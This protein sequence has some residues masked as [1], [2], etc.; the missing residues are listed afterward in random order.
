[1]NCIHLASFNGN[2]GDLLSHQGTYVM[3]QNYVKKKIKFTEFEIRDIYNKK[4]K[5]DQDFVNYVNTFDFLMI[6]GGNY[7]ELWVK[8]SPTGT[9][10]SIELSLL[11]KIKIPIL[12]NSMGVDIS[13]GA[14]KQNIKKFKRFI[15][16]LIKKNA[17][18]SF[19]NDGSKYNL[20]KIFRGDRIFNKLNFVPDCGFFYKKNY[21]K[22]NNKNVLGVNIAGDMDS[23][24][25]KNKKN[26]NKNL[27]YFVKTFLK[28][29]IKNKIFLFPHIYKDYKSIWN[30]LKYIEDDILRKRIKI[31]ELDACKE[32]LSIF[33]KNIAKCSYM[34]SM[35]FHS[36]IASI[37]Y[38]IPTVGLLN[39]PQIGFLYKELNIENRLINTNVDNYFYKLNRIYLNDQKN[40]KSIKNNYKLINKRNLLLGKKNFI[41]INNWL[42]SFAF[43]LR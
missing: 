39:H 28:K 24:R 30:F 9:S 27:S 2:I 34:L 42:N 8:D 33:L 32:G 23:F 11:K 43:N 20:K 36:N 29:N 18:L 7:F 22:V 16:H 25:Y 14:S 31:C 40:L 21:K 38:N 41:K 35:R 1:M 13:Q 6:G 4:K 19:R 37:L 3:F 10:I 12:I 15:N 26:F 17:Y 5:F